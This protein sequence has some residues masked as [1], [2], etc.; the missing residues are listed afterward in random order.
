MVLSV[1]QYSAHVNQYPLGVHRKG[2]KVHFRWP[3]TDH[4]VPGRVISGDRYST[5]VCASTPCTVPVN[6]GV[7]W[8][9]VG[10]P[11]LIAVRP[12]EVHFVEADPTWSPYSVSP[13]LTPN[14]YR[15]LDEAP[16]L[17]RRFRQSHYGAYMPATYY[18]QD[19]PVWVWEKSW[20]R[21]IVVGSSRSWV[22]VALL[23][24]YRDRKGIVHHK[25]FHPPYVWPAICDYPAPVQHIFTGTTED[26][27]EIEKPGS[28]YRPGAS[29]GR[30]MEKWLR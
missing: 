6:W 17:V 12:G 11:T 2:D 18:L 30:P 13:F 25:G 15:L 27:P 14:D 29:V 16:T 7:R 5:R 1:S 10:T 28:I 20:F 3:G 4:W 8:L 24:E 26:S 19:D 21:A 23:D 9:P 22:N